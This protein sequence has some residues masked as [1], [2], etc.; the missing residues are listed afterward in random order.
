MVSVCPDSLPVFFS[1]GFFFFVFCFLS[2]SFLCIGKSLAA[3]LPVPLIS[4][5][6]FMTQS[7]R[8]SNYFFFLFFFFFFFFLY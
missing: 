3:I 4:S 8:S 7:G 6:S 1:T 2:P 5:S